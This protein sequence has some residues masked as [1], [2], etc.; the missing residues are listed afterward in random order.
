MLNL[1]KICF[2]KICGSCCRRSSGMVLDAG[3]P[4]LTRGA[5]KKGCSNANAG[6]QAEA[7]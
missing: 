2:K 7:G 4:R 3:P 5:Q 1:T 6:K